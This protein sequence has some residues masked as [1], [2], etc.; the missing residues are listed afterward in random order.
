MISSIVSFMLIFPVA[1]SAAT[2]HLHG[3]VLAVTPKTGEVIVR[4]DA[5]GAMPGMTMSFRVLPRSRARELQPGAIIDATVD[6]RTEPWTLH[7]LTSTAA[8]S[9]TTEPV[10]R[11]VTPLHVG[12]IVPDT[13]FLDQRR[14]P[15][16]FASLRGQDVVL[17]FVY[18]RCQDARM[19]PLISA[20]FHRLQTLVAKK[21]VH[22]VEVTL[23][24]TFDRPSVLSR[25]GKAFGADPTRWT[26][27]VGDANATL[28]FA[29]RF[30]IT[31]FPDPNLGIIHAEN[32]V[33]IGP[34]GRIDEMI[35]ENSWAPDELVAQIDQTH[36][37]ANNPLRRF[38]LWLSSAAVAMCGNAVG[39][40]SGLADL[41]IVL[42]I[43]GSFGY[44][45]WRVA[46][47]ILVERT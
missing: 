22:L 4:H 14:A 25:Y 32:T 41:A 8:Q 19:C 10:L 42:L 40:F 45:L 9:L 33:L 43:F 31:A 7:N 34:D 39:G 15:F 18:T 17:A 13:P 26:L 11:R 16:S 37:V 24:P 28:D 44:L 2:A 20:K 21:R 6:T 36:G 23:D 27:A 12:D 1:A 29:A 47:K 5:L 3:I 35:T 38:D 30:G 46:R